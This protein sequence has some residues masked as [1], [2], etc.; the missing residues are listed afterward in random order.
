M[1]V[2]STKP[3]DVPKIE[4]EVGELRGITMEFGN[5]PMLIR[6][7]IPKP[8]HGEATLKRL[9]NYIRLRLFLDLPVLLYTHHDYF[10]NGIDS[11]N[12]IAMTINEIQPKVVWSNLGDV[13]RNLYLQRKINER[14][15]EVLAL[16]RHVVL[17]NTYENP[18]KWIFKKQEDLSVPIKEV[19]VDGKRRAYTYD[20]NHIKIEFYIDPGMQ[21]EIIIRY[22]NLGEKTN[23]LYDDRSLPAILIR[24]LSDFRDIYLIKMPFGGSL[25]SLVY[26][27][28]GMKKVGSMLLGSGTIVVILIVL[29]VWTRSKRRTSE[30]G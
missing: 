14:V 25:V 29:L 1:T 2:N 28:G 6:K 7:G 27:M 16:T 18:K 26:K 24:R 22:D 9:E 10:K 20:G 8:P 17:H 30:G 5:F 21:K 3:F 11:F 19:L 13:A 12:S 15:V 23:Y 4:D